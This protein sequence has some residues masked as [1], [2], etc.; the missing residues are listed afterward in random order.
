LVKK[1]FQNW[2]HAMETFTNHVTLQYQKQS[3]LDADHFIDMKN[4][5][6]LSIKNQL[7]TART[8]KFFENRKNIFPVIETIILC[9]QQNIPLRCYNIERWEIRKM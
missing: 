6:H 8:R 2:K 3:V 9:G 5:A 4:N 7:D 1:P